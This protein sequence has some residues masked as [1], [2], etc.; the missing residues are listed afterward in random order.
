MRGVTGGT[1]PAAIWKEVMQ[2]AEKGLAPRP[3]DRSP[4]EEAIDEGVQPSGP[5]STDDE[6]QRSVQNQPEAQQVP[7][8]EQPKKGAVGRF[9]N[10][11]FG[12]DDDKPPATTP[13]PQ[14]D[15]QGN[16]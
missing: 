12:S 6:S 9:F 11:L 3:L 16:Q 7:A 5:V 2:T 1:L 8:S 13:P 10:W 4:P 14:S 15:D